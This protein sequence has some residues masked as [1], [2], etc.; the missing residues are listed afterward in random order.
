[1]NAVFRALAGA[2]CLAIVP[3]AADAAVLTKTF[4]FQASDFAPFPGSGVSPFAEVTGSV[5]VTWDNSVDVIDQFTGVTVNSLSIPY[6]PQLAFSYIRSV[7]VLRVG[8]A[9]QSSQMS[10]SSNDFT[11]SIGAASLANH[12]SVY[13]AFS[14]ANAN[15]TNFFRANELRI[16]DVTGV[17]E[18]A[19]WALMI[20]GFGLAGAA[21]RRRA[22]QAS[23][24]VAI[25]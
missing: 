4:A 20:A 21:L 15:V 13:T 1:M 18:P 23:Q 17:P 8:A 22:S 16:A 12:D 9:N 5:T 3:A 10:G 25:A 19:S 7:D 2:A 11:L 24:E 6:Q 14:F